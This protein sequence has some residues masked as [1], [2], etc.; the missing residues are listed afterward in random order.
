[1]CTPQLVCATCTERSKR[2]QTCAISASLE[3]TRSCFILTEKMQAKSLKS[4]DYRFS[5]APRWIGAKVQ[6]IQMIR[7]LRVHVHWEIKRNLLMANLSSSL[8]GVL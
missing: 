1:V 2:V 8:Q 5:V 7:A 3:Y 4:Q 6:F